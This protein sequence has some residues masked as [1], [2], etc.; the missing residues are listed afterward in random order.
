MGSGRPGS[1]YT[2]SVERATS[3]WCFS[4]CAVSIHQVR[5]RRRGW[6]ASTTS[7][8]PS[9]IDAMPWSWNS[10]VATCAAS[11]V[12]GASSRR[13]RS[14]PGWASVVSLIALSGSAPGVSCHEKNQSAWPSRD[15]VR[16]RGPREA[17]L[18]TALRSF[19]GTSPTFAT[20][21]PSMLH[22]STVFGKR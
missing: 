19:S 3:T 17:T 15:H 7:S 4:G 2:P 10:D 16:F 18:E 8:L 12:N 1:S 22:S 5:S 21:A 6:Y 9:P 11:P 20:I 13:R 14:V